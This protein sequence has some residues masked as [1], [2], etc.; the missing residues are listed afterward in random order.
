METIRVLVVE[1]EARQRAR[2]RRLLEAQSD[3]EVIGES[4]NGRAALDDIR[5]LKPTLVLLDVQMPEMT[6]LEV[7]EALEPEEVPAVIFVT[8][9]DQYA[10]RAFELHALDYLLK[11]FDDDRFEEVMTRAST[12]IRQGQVEQLGLK[13]LDLLQYLNVTPD[14]A[15]K[16]LETTTPY[17]ERLAIKSSGR[18][19][20]LK[21]HDID[22]IAGAGV[23]VEVY[24]QTHR[25]LL[26]QTLRKL[27]E[28]LDPERFVR[29][30]RSTIVNV[31]RIKELI[32]HLHGEYVVVLDNGKKL[33]LSRS[34]RDKL[35][36]I[37]G[38]LE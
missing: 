14:G 2:L 3:Y 1:D 24:T 27:E 30:H 13:L 34:Y 37:L 25:H 11:P 20:L 12:R 36:V 33:K 38:N 9:Y 8:A 15:S 17:L 5:K 18:L 31:D 26:R 21:T 10:L 29:I 35:E 23:Y 16:I 28:S 4:A 6:G 32:P 7:I 19:T 22:W